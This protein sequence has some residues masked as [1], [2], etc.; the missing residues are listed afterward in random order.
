MY[1]KTAIVCLWF[2]T[3]YALLVFMAAAWWQA[4][5][6]AI[7]LGLAMAAI[8]FNIQHDGA[9]G[10]Y[11][12]FRWI[13][14]LSALTLDMLGGSSYAWDR[15]H[16]SIHHTY[17][18]ITGHDEDINLGLLGRLS[19][20]QKRLRIHRFQHLYLWVL[21]GFL[22]IKWQVY[23][24]FRDILKGRIGGQQLVRPTGWDLVVFISGKSAFFSLALLI[25]ALSCG[26]G[27][28]IVF[29]FV[30][31]F[32]QGVTLSVVFQLAH[33]VEN[34][35]FPVPD[36]ETGQIENAWA[37]HQVQ[38]TVDFARNNRLISWFTGGLNFQIEHH[39]FPRI[40]HVNY[41]AISGLVEKTCR[42]LGINYAVHPTFFAGIA[43]H[44][45]W[46]RRMGQLDTTDQ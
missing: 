14:R 26:V 41:P 37:I 5:P 1:V 8:G 7:S 36:D 19:P 31:T 2:V 34:A 3:S 10:A 28:T 13:N 46:L 33:C 9:H 39:L 11:S 25:P 23:D 40:C 15:S 30:A 22:A 35:E 20:H 43:S 4:L 38:T 21:Y 24:D 6:L 27:V 44:F 16:N 45:R 17:A 29:Y 18:N 42:E 32:V 12:N